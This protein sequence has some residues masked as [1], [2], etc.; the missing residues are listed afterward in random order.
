MITLGIDTSCDDT[1]IAVLEDSNIRANLISSHLVHTEYGGVVPEFA[2]RAH[3]ML[4]YPMIRLALDA[5]RVSLEDLSLIAVTSGPGLLG[6][7]L[8]GLAFAKGLSLATGIPLRTV[9]HLEGHIYSVLLSYP[10]LEP[11]FIVLLVSGG[12]TELIRVRSSFDYEQIGATLDDAC[13]EA[14]DKVGKLMGLGYPAGPAVERLAVESKNPVKLPV[15]NP[16][17]MDFSY[18]GLKTAARNYLEAH[19]E[20]SHADLSLGLMDAA[21]DHLV[22]RVEKAVDNLGVYK[23][24]L[25]GGVAINKSLRKKLEDSGKRKG[26]TLYAPSA[27]LCT[28]NA[29]MI[30]AAG[31]ARYRVFGPSPMNEAAYDRASLGEIT[32]A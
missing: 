9:D 24:G 3:A 1:S 5:A 19:P 10:D 27:S 16:G 32:S 21:F 12:H 13:G 29:A 8:C 15:P 30:A 18:S 23:I 17:G 28:D 22:A 31:M 2:S 6:S 11:P 14:L 20:T 7:L 4:L 26:F 25:A